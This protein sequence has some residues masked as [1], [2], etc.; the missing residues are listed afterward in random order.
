MSRTKRIWNEG[1]LLGRLKDIYQWYDEQGVF[2]DRLYI[3]KKVSMDSFGHYRARNMRK[4]IRHSIRV[5]NRCMFARNEYEP[6]IE[7][8]GEYFD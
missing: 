2:H 4:A 6:I 8:G 1:Y 3:W 7:I 5:Q